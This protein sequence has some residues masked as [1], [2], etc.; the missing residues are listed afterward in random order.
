MTLPHVALTGKARAGKDTA[1]A[2]LVE[3]HG[4]TR[5]AFADGVREVALAIDPYV[6]D[7]PMR[8]SEMVDFGGWEDAK[9]S[10]EVRR[11]L[12][13]IGTEAGRRYFGAEVWVDLALRKA[14]KIDGP[15]V[16]TDCRF[17]NEADAVA[18]DLGGL[19]VRI[20]RTGAGAGEHA[21]ETAM[22]GYPF[23]HVVTNDGTVEELHAALDRIV[24]R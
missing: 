21:S 23:D 10:P 13:V 3:R 24:A 9:R 12:Q 14:A 8:L 2:Y 17:P 6:C 19:V 4:Y 22:D 5:V 20:E 11:L 15:V 18:V 1:G 16:F 7:C